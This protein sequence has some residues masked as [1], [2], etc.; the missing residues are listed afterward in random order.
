MRTA[1]SVGEQTV[2]KIINAQVA[3]L[4]CEAC[5]YC[6][7]TKNLGEICQDFYMPFLFLIFCRSIQVITPSSRTVDN[8]RY[9]HRSYAYVSFVIAVTEGQCRI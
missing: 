8:Y 2:T 9:A 1:S 6:N 5:A 3:A 7:L 4:K